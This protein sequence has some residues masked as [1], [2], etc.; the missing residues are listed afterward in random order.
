MRASTIVLTAFLGLFIFSTTSCSFR[1]RTSGNRTKSKTVMTK[2]RNNPH[3]P[4]TT[5]PGRGHER[6]G[7]PGKSGSKGRGR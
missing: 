2:N 7:T 1:L 6:K 4:N 5:N 3:H